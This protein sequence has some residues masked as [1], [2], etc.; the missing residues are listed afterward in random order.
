[1]VA[2]YE[3]G[4]MENGVITEMKGSPRERILSHSCKCVSE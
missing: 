3:G 1:M 4:V 2:K